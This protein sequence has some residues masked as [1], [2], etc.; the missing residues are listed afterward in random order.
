MFFTYQY[1]I[2]IPS[3]YKWLLVHSSITCCRVIVQGAHSKMQIY[4]AIELVGCKSERI[5]H[6]ASVRGAW[7]NI[8]RR[9]CTWPSA[10]H[11]SDVRILSAPPCHLHYAS[12]V[13]PFPERCS[14]SGCDECL[15]VVFVT[16]H[17]F[18]AVEAWPS[19]HRV[20][21]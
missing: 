2:I 6:A 15:I 3:V 9:Y 11:T 4:L 18:R 17:P 21:F 19:K 16:R 7:Q 12:S 14:S 8:S 10:T 1:T 13:I 5:C 20:N